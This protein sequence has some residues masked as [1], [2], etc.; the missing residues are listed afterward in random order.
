MTP[1]DAN[2]LTLVSDDASPTRE[3]AEEAVRTL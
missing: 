2:K 1:Y 3:E